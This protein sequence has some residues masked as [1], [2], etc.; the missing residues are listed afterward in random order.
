L[1]D[2]QWLPTSMANCKDFLTLPEGCYSPHPKL[3]MTVVFFE[4]NTE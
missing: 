2:C 4:R 3:E 1:P